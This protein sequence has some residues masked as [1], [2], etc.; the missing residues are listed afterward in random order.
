MIKLYLWDTAGQERFRNIT[1]TYYR[2]AGA[3]VIVYDITDYSSYES[4]SRWYS[5]VIEGI[6]KDAIFILVG[7]KSDL[8]HRRAVS[9]QQG[10][11]FAEEKG[12][13]FYETS[14]KTG[15]NLDEIFQEI[16]EKF[17]SYEKAKNKV[18]NNEL[19]GTPVDAVS[20]DMSPL[21]QRKCCPTG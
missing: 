3:A 12:L 20:I 11:I 2:H 8:E 13:S 9:T 5:D 14:A 7:N 18:D 21:S 17:Y 19:E 10:K 15:A 1:K 4:V 16:A 6:G